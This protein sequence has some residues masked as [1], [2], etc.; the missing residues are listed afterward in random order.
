MGWVDMDGW[1]DGW[2]GGWVDGWM[3]MYSSNG[4]GSNRVF[5]C[6]T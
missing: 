1:V 6:F 5:E 2:M 3:G 4:T